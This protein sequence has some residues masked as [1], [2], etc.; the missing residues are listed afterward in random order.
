MASSGSYNF[1]LTRDDIINLAHQHVSA[2]GEGETASTA[3][4]SEASNLLNM[5]VKLRAADGMPLW[6]L[7]R[8]YILPFTAA[9][10][11]NT[12]SH[13]VTFYDATSV[14][15]AAAASATTIVIAAAGTI[16]NSDQIGIE[17]DDGNMNWT[18]VSAGGGTT[19]LTIATGITAAAAVGS[20]VYAYTAS[21]DRIQKPLRIVDMDIKLESAGTRHP[22]NIITSQEYYSLGSP[23][24]EGT[25]NQ[26]FYDRGPSSDTALETNGRFFVYPR[27]QTGDYVIEFTYQRPFQ[28]FD[29]ASDNPDFPQAFYLPLMLELAA[30]LGPK[31]GLP[32]DERKLLRLDAQFYLDQALMTIQPEGS[33]YAQPES[34]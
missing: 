28:D 12:D 21:A 7:K 3:Q 29:A 18:T 31:F 5:I 15:T 27:F 23:T 8:G 22:I 9:S 33:L 30:L 17:D 25:P 32:T 11:I 24:S 2:I 13:V 10:S 14:A 6:A 26:V 19:S 20:R 1:T 4:L 16:A 34:R